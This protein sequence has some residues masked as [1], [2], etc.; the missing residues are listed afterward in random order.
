MIIHISLEDDPNVVKVFPDPAA[1]DPE[2]ELID[3]LGQLTL[4]VNAEQTGPIDVDIAKGVQGPPG[5]G[6]GAGIPRDT[7][8]YVTSSLV[9]GTGENATFGLS[10]SYTI[11][12]VQCSQTGVRVRGYV[13]AA[14]RTADIARPIGSYP[15]AIDHGLLFEVYDVT[16]LWLPKPADGFTVDDSGFV[17]V[18]IDNAGSTNPV[19]VTLTFITTEE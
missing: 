8:T 9:A 12:R 17:P 15:S 7:E 4:T 19:T 18:R 10:S 2:Y 3:S 6:G 5:S 11:L 14:H 16:D 1:T 13:T